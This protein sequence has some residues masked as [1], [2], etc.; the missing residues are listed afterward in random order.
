MENTFISKIGKKDL[1]E[2][3]SLCQSLNFDFD[4]LLFESIVVNTLKH[5]KGDK[6]K[7]V[8]LW[9]VLQ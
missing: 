1:H 2:F 5:L 3:I 8:C 4:E 6:E 9:S 7:R